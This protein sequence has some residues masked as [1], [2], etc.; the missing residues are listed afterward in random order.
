[1][2]IISRDAKLGETSG[3]INAGYGNYNRVDVNGAVNVPLGEKAAPLAFALAW[4]AMIDID[5]FRLPD[6][7]TLPMIAGGSLYAWLIEH[8]R[9]IDCAIGAAAGYLSLVL[10]AEVFRLLRGKDGLGRGDAKL[11]AAAGAWLGW[12]A[13]PAVVFIAAVTGI[14]FAVVQRLTR[15]AHNHATAHLIPFGPFIATSFWLLL[16]TGF[17]SAPLLHLIE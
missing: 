14:A 4:A 1:V 9:L 2:N 11:L 16:V 12:A 6:I 17:Q 5:R 15:D 8:P 13:L 10:V 3:Y 7:L